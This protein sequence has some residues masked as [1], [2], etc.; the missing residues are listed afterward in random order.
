MKHHVAV[1]SSDVNSTCVERRSPY[2]DFDEPLPVDTIDTFTRALD[3]IEAS[4][5]EM[6]P[7][8]HVIAASR[9]LCSA[10]AHSVDLL[11]QARIDRDRYVDVVCAIAGGG[12]RAGQ[13][14]V[15]FIQSSVGDRLIKIGYSKYPMGRL[16]ALQTSSGHSLV[17]LH[18]MSGTKRD[19]ADLHRRFR[20]LRA[21]G[22]WFRPGNTLVDHV[23]SLAPHAPI[24]AP[25][26]Q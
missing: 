11:R 19:E 6:L 21:R 12:P 2:A 16:K 13:D 24:V 17:L 3:A 5:Q 18:T 26:V 14:Q 10:F 20:N 1:P 23:R 9:A 25:F 7:A 22:E 4:G 15:Y 8:V